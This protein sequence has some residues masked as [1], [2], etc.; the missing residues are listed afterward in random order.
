VHL[1]VENLDGINKL[2]KILGNNPFISQKSADFELFK[3]A[4]ELINQG[5]H[6]TKEGLEKIVAIK[7]SM[8]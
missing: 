7:A 6:L 1:Q 3:K 5:E 2:I 4:V 8:N